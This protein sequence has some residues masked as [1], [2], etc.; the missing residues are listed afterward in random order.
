MAGPR[1]DPGLPDS[2]VCVLRH[3]VPQGT[4]FESFCQLDYKPL[5][6]RESVSLSLQCLAL[7][8]HIIRVNKYLLCKYLM[9]VTFFVPRLPSLLCHSYLS[10]CP[11]ISWRHKHIC[12]K[13]SSNAIL[14]L[15]HLASLHL[16]IH[17]QCQL[18]PTCFSR[19]FPNRGLSHGD[20]SIQL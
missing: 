3:S 16:R 17:L 19:S 1:L 13:Y 12:W 7:C 10:Q 6:D 18:R 20:P 14:G 5:E 9:N 11:G 4:C 15:G 8:W 2:K